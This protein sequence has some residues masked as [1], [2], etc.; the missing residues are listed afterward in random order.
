MKALRVSPMKARV[1]TNIWFQ[2]SS[3]GSIF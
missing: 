1:L 3:D 2:S